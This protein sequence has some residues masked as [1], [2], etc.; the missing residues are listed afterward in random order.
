MSQHRWTRSL[1]MR[2]CYPRPDWL[3]RARDEAE[4]QT[5][6]EGLMIE[7]EGSSVGVIERRELLRLLRGWWPS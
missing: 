7:V 1:P 4:F 5:Q 2:G 3:A 6:L